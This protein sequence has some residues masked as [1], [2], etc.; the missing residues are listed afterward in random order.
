VIE[1]ANP[2][3][4][5]FPGMTA[6]VTISTEP[7]GNALKLPNAALRFKPPESLLE[8]RP[9][10]N[11]AASGNWGT[12]YVTTPNSKLRAVPVKLGITDGNFT[13]ILEGDIGEGQR[14]VLGI[15][16]TAA[17]PFAPAAPSMLPS[18]PVVDRIGCGIDCSGVRF[19]WTGG[20]LFRLLSG[21]QS[22]VP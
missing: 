12:V 6:N 8:G 21:P 2:E 9:G 1:V 4:K 18:C 20:N 11:K 13:E 15:R 5:L 19:L 10:A 16:T 22:S 7:R 14:V 3:L 17:T